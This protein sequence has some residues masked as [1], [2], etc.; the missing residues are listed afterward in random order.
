MGVLR[1]WPFEQMGKNSLT[2]WNPERCPGFGKQ[3]FCCSHKLLLP[4]AARFAARLS[5]TRTQSFE[6]GGVKLCRP[7]VVRVP[8]TWYEPSRGLNHQHL[9][10]DPGSVIFFISTVMLAELPFGT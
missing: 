1:P 3:P 9:A 5:I 4:G 10:W 8:I 7:L 6:S 2:A